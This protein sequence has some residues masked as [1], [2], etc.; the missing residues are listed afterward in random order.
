MGSG[1]VH[2][3]VDAAEVLADLRDGVGR[4]VG[5]DEVELPRPRAPSA[6]D[7]LV[8]DG[9]RGVVVLA[10]GHRDVAAAFREHASDDGPEPS[11]PARHD[12]P[13]GQPSEVVHAV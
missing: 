11:A 1:R 3:R 2:E 10:I 8:D 7:D 4:R 13:T 6:G 12:G 9:T 5:V